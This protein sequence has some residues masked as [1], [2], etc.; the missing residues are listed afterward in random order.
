[1]APAKSRFAPS[2]QTVA[3]GRGLYIRRVRSEYSFSSVFSPCVILSASPLEQNSIM[4]DTD[5]GEVAEATPPQPLMLSNGE[6]AGYRLPVTG[7]PWRPG[8]TVTHAHAHTHRLRT[9][10]KAWLRPFNQFAGVNPS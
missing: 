9:L 7:P 1:M 5:L 10:F 8:L 6:L 4:G 3:T 2:G